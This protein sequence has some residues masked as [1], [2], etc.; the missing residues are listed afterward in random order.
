MLTFY[1][2]KPFRINK[3]E[4]LSTHRANVRPHEGTLQD[5]IQ[6]SKQ[7]VILKFFSQKSSLNKQG[8]NSIHTQGI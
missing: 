8:R 2:Q 1:S 6:P 3:A 4:I 7:A 5:L